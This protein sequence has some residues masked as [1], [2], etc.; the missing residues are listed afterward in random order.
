MRVKKSVLSEEAILE[1]DPVLADANLLRRQLGD[2]ARQMRRLRDGHGVTASKLSA[3]G[4]LHRA[5]GPL[6]A[7]ELATLEGLKPQSVTRIIAELEEERFIKRESS[8]EDRRQIDIFLTE[9]GASL[10]FEDASRQNE[11]IS[12]A[13]K[14]GLTRAERAVLILAGELL[15]RLVH[16]QNVSAGR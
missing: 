7:S 1:A 9:K 6:T 16:P 2:F 12:Q 11:W 8:A 13:M 14:K 3:L 15:D 4:Q 10:L 5:Q